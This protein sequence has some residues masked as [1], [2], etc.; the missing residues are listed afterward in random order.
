MMT[1]AAACERIAELETEVAYLRELALPASKLGTRYPAEW[2]LS[3]IN[4]KLLTALAHGEPGVP[5]P[6][7]RL[8]LA[9]FGSRDVNPKDITVYICNLRRFLRPLGMSI[10]N[11][12][13]EGYRL[14]PDDLRR[15]KASAIPPEKKRHAR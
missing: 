3:P 8:H 7:E 13:Y 14:L 4:A 11:V 1:L 9:L 6:A 2:G 15:V 10:D 12:K 5:I